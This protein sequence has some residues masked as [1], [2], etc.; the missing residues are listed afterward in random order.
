MAIISLVLSTL[1]FV[2]PLVENRPKHLLVKERQ[3]IGYKLVVSEPF[4]SGMKNVWCIKFILAGEKNETGEVGIY[5][6]VK[7]GTEEV[8]VFKALSTQEI[9][10]YTRVAFYSEKE[11]R[12]SIIESINGG[13][14]F[15]TAVYLVYIE[16]G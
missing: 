14:I 12:E 8:S 10:Q 2:S 4:Q 9:E 13:K 15:I 7:N 3:E 1:M 5:E 6:K 11:T 16:N